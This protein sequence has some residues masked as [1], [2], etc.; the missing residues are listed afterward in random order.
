MSS[1]GSGTS[2]A[3]FILAL[4]RHWRRFV[5]KRSGFEGGEQSPGNPGADTEITSDGMV[6]HPSFKGLLE[7]GPAV[8]TMQTTT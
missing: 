1:S 5:L 8:A 7:A 6:R 2:A 4:S 3:M